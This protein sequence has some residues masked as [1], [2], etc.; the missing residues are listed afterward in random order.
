MKQK[1]KKNKTG[2]ERLLSNIA[3]GYE[4]S[5]VVMMNVPAN[6]AV[7]IRG[8]PTRSVRM[9]GKLTAHTPP[10]PYASGAVYSPLLV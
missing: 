8:R 9:R 5:G 1:K 2:G 6:M 10:L 7:S 4:S 3:R